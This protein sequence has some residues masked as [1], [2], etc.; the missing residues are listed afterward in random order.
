VATSVST[1]I[2]LTTPQD[3]IYLQLVR[4]CAMTDVRSNLSAN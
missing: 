2:K 1:I 4:Y 3:Y